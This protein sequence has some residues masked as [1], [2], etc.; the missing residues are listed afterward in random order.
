MS[1]RV[2][3]TLGVIFVA[4]A[5]VWT[6][7]GERIEAIATPDRAGCPQSSDEPGPK[8]ANEARA[9]VLCLLN[10]HRAAAGLTVLVEDPALQA[11]AQAHADDMGR[12][13]FYAHRD[14]DGVTP[15]QRIRRAGFNGQA[16]GENI[17]WGVGLNASPAH[18][19]DGWMASPGHRANI[20]RASFSRVGT[21]IGYDAPDRLTSGRAGVYVNNFG[22]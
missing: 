2:R 18:I 7:A 4:L 9:A 12:R 10:Q 19:V 22:G 8:N 3:Q 16:T 5:L 11:A 1:V 17:H 6:V 13:D 14:P 20:L 15:D 21:G